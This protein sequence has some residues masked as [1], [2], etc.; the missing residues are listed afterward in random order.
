MPRRKW[1]LILFCPVF[2]PVDAIGTLNFCIPEL[3]N[4][5]RNLRRQPKKIHHGD[6]ENQGNGTWNARA[7]L[8]RRIVF[9]LPFLRAS[10]SRW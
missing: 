1:R 6:T 2:R 10:V 5:H 4:P 9:R 7:D 8:H 3:Q